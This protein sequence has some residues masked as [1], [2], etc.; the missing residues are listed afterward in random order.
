MLLATLAAQNLNAQTLATPPNAN[1]PQN[2]AGNIII[3]DPTEDA[4]ITKATPESRLSAIASPE[5]LVTPEFTQPAAQTSISPNT[6]PVEKMVVSVVESSTNKVSNTDI[7][8]PKNVASL[9]GQTTTNQGLQQ[10]TKLA[11]NPPTEN[12]QKIAQRELE[13]VAPGVQRTPQPCLEIDNLKSRLR[14]VEDI[15]PVEEFQAS[16]ALSIAIPTGY[17]ADKN[18]A[19]ISATYQN[20]TRYT[21]VSDGGL[22]IGV[23]LGDAQ[24]SVG[25]ELSYTLASFGG[26]RDIGTGGF[27]VKV[28]RQLPNDLAVA[29]GYN[30]L[31]NI[32]GHNDFENSA[33]GTVTKVFRTREDINQPFS[34]VA[35]T[36]GVGSGQFRSE[37]AI[38]KNSG[39]IGVF[40]NVAVRV[41]KPVSVIA[42]WSGQDLGLGVSVAP[43]KN[44]P[45]VITPAVRDIV[46]AGNG[47]RFVLGAGVGFKF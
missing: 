5:S 10:V 8:P 4:A 1:Q 41:A 18:T 6:K 39:G 30:G 31:V 47:P 13:F 32:G 38:N 19:F 21:K 2:Q 35:V 22:G 3:P 33:Y 28:H 23:G 45:L 9:A 46:G 12:C 20:R 36:A 44:I 37:S 14:A 27:N 42:E 15:K 25:V 17:G 34:R 24:K 40:G 29:A 26:S 16:P 11:Q 43:F 7:T